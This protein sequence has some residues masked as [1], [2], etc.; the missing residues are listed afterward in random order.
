ML[1]ALREVQIPL[2]AVLLIGGSAAKATRAFSARSLEA[3]AGPTTLLPL[4]L[5]RPLA[6]AIGMTEMSLGVALVVTVGSFGAGAPAMMAR[7]LTALLFVT[8]VGIL[9][10]LRERRPETGCG[11]FGDLSP[12]PVSWRVLVRSALLAV[13]ALGTVTAGPLRALGPPEGVWIMLGIAAAEVAALAALSPEIGEV[14]VRLGYSEPCELR[15]IPVTRTL[16]A[17]RGSAQWRRYRRYLT[18]A[19]PDDVWR[20]G[21]WRYVVF[22]GIA[23]GLAVDIVFAVFMQPRRPTVRTVIV[24]AMTDRALTAHTVPFQRP[25]HPPSADLYDPIKETQY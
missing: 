2:L 19:E 21:C 24:D 4:R 11:C 6:V 5:R 25:A 13:A 7:T 12:G 16:S 3:A 14:M 23:D 10:E 17:L 15:R 20:E 18:A 1:S 22:P 9:Y 8:A